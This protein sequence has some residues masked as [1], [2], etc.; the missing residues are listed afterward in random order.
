MKA[1]NSSSRR[2]RRSSGDNVFKITTIGAFKQKYN[3][4]A[5]CRMENRYILLTPLTS[6]MRHFLFLFAASL[7]FN[8]NLF[9]QANNTFFLN[10]N[11]A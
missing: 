3:G 1:E 6:G 2:R 7:N 8:R 4:R 11:I 9:P 5:K 10:D